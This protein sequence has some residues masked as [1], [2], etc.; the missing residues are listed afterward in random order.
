[1]GFLAD[2]WA[3]LMWSLRTQTPVGGEWLGDQLRLLFPPDGSE[4]PEGERRLVILADLDRW[5]LQLAPEKYL[6]RLAPMVEAWVSKAPKEEVAIA[7]QM[8]GDEAWLAGAIR[9]VKRSDPG[10]GW[11]GVGLMMLQG[12]FRKAG[13]ISKARFYD[14]HKFEVIVDW[15]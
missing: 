1:M 4:P 5:A 11:S 6:G 14:K 2:I 9:Q 7:A 8:V 15:D 13:L 12:S 10:N 3:K